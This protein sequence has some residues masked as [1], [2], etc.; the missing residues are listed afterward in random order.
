[1]TGQPIIGQRA[2]ALGCKIIQR[3]P[4]SLMSPVFFPIQVVSRKIHSLSIRFPAKGINIFPPSKESIEDCTLT[5][6]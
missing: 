5:L 6:D 1:M 3:S 2:G 4:G